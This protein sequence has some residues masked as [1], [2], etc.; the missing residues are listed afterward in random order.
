M[1]LGTVAMGVPSGRDRA[2]S[3]QS[4]A[5]SGAPLVSKKMANGDG[6]T[7]PIVSSVGA[8]TADS[9]FHSLANVASTRSD[10]QVSG[11]H[12]GFATATQWPPLLRLDDSRLDCSETSLRHACSDTILRHAKDNAPGF[13][14]T[15][16]DDDT[17]QSDLRAQFSS[18][19]PP[20]RLTAATV[21]SK[22]HFLL[23]E[24]RLAHAENQ[25]LRELVRRMSEMANGTGSMHTNGTGS[26]H[27]DVLPAQLTPDP[28]PP[29]TARDTHGHAAQRLRNLCIILHH[30]LLIAHIRLQRDR[31]YM[32]LIPIGILLAIAVLQLVTL[33]LLD[34]RDTLEWNMEGDW[35]L[36]YNLDY[37]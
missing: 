1:S 27:V 30:Q 29:S 22:A 23:E 21:L 33:C 35:S 10:S 24:L 19:P 4:A 7:E 25:R 26:T 20:P 37:A 6:A 3:F 9:A 28:S 2:L 5:M 17:T 14:L 18:N 11:R 15:S 34:V 32:L 12:G 13:R 31:M 16:I 36:L 8:M